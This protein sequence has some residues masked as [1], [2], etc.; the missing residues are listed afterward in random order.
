MA[1]PTCDICKGA[2]YYLLDRPVGHPEFGQLRPC[3]C[4][5]ERQQERRL[6]ALRDASQLVGSLL[7]KSF[8]N[9]R[10]RRAAQQQALQAARHFAGNPRG[11][12]VFAGSNGSGKTHL[13]AAI[14]NDRLANARPAL[15]VVVPDLLDHLRSTYHPDSKV[16]FDAR[17]EEIRQHPLLILDDL[18][19]HSSTDWAAEKLFQLINHRYNLELATVYTTNQ[20]VRDMPLRLRARLGDT[21][22][23]TVVNVDQADPRQ[24]TTSQH[25]DTRPSSPRM[26]F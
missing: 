12:L 17:F 8:D 22:I 4:T 19:A 21:K 14:A 15:F 10:P 16:S 2:G 23:A 24:Q 18:G 26:R 11:W 6:Q 5:I 9:Y 20:R 13:A 7:V 3:K 1:E 25:A